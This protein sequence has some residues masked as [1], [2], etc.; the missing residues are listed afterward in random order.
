MMRAGYVWPAIVMV[1]IVVAHHAQ[2]DPTHLSLM[3]DPRGEFIRLCAP[4]KL[5]YAHPE[6]VCDCLRSVILDEVDDH[7][8]SNE[9]LF[10]ITERGAPSVIMTY[11]SVQA[12]ERMS[13]TMTAIARPTMECMFGD[14]RQMKPAV[15]VPF[16]GPSIL[17]PVQDL[18]P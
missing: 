1:A 16:D 18:T 10:G 17:P 12:K 8:L 9:L 11:L 2:A 15:P 5:T 3:P 6:Q 4:T 14:R 7:R 13:Q